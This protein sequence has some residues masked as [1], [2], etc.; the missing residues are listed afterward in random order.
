[1]IY[2]CLQGYAGLHQ[3]HRRLPEQQQQ[4]V[5]EAAGHLFQTAAVFS[6][7]DQATS[8][9]EQAD[10]TASCSLVNHVVQDTLQALTGKCDWPGSHVRSAAMTKH[11]FDICPAVVTIVN[12]CASA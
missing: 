7:A 8:Y 6:A 2:G 10:L 4:A 1:M 3:A 9:G 5:Q 12:D 11:V